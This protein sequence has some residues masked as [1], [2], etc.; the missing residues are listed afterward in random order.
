MTT[1]TIQGRK[2]TTL[3]NQGA[4]AFRPTTKSGNGTGVSDARTDHEGSSK[5][6]NQAEVASNARTP[7]HTPKQGKKRVWLIPREHGAYAQLLL[8]LIAAF[9]V[10]GATLSGVTF[11]GA[12]LAAF[13]GTEALRT[14]LG[15]RGRRKQQQLRGL[16]RRWLTA[17]VLLALSFALLGAALAPTGAL[18]A[19]LL[20]AGLGSLVVLLVL[21]RREKTVPGEMLAASAL[22]ACAV[23]VALTGGVAWLD[24]GLMLVAFVLVFAFATV[25]V[26]LVVRHKKRPVAWPA[27]LAVGAAAITSLVAG[28]TLGALAQYPFAAAASLA[29]LPVL[30]TVTVLATR[31]PHPRMLR[32]IGWTLAAMTT[33][34]TLLL[35]AGYH[36]VA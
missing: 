24:A 12:F 33:L 14:L 32:Q 3:R 23:P 21:L 11:A 4:K 29:A 28:F 27:R 1:E 19:L 34:M 18:V 10:G 25:A 2:D 17:T 35:I 36:Y 22:S 20:P 31:P 8:P 30:G 5:A 26:H 6:A 9:A 13:A 7:T 16:A 15:H